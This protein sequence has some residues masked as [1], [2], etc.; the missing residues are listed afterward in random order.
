MAVLFSGYITYCFK[1][2]HELARRKPPE[3]A[4][5]P[6]HGCA[7]R[8]QLLRCFLSWTPI[9]LRS[10]LQH[11]IKKTYKRTNTGN[12]QKRQVTCLITNTHNKATA[13]KGKLPVTWPCYFLAKGQVPRIQKYLETKSRQPPER[14]SYPRTRLKCFLSWRRIAPLLS[15]FFPIEMSPLFEF[16]YWNLC[17][18]LTFVLKSLLSLNF[19]IQIS[20]FS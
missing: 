1:S 7:I 16:S 5:S 8:L 6:W 13:R 15:F 14:A 12:C 20:T 17:F 9:A 4:S 18:L 10:D 11:S 3:K 2:V 19:R